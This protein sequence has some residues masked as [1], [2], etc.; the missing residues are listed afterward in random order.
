M[1]GFNIYF[2]N[3][4]TGH[5]ALIAAAIV[6]VYFFVYKQYKNRSRLLIFTRI[7][8]F[9]VLILMIL[10]P[11]ISWQSRQTLKSE[12]LFFIDNSLSF[13]KQENYDRELIH[14]NIK[15]LNQKL[16]DKGLKPTYFSFA[17]EL[18]PIPNL[19][20]LDNKGQNTNLANIL[21]YLQSQKNR[22][23]RGALIVS[24]GVAT[25][26]QVPTSFDNY[27]TGPVFTSGLGDTAAQRDAS[28]LDVEMPGTA[29]VDDTVNISA[30]INPASRSSQIQVSLKVDGETIQTKQIKGTSSYQRTTLDFQYVP[31]KPGSQ[32]IE[33]VIEDDQDKNLFN[34]Q[35]QRNMKITL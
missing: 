16:Q 33:M 29:Q 6:L 17:E 13:A 28:L 4:E 9:I 3:F 21:T 11:V 22:N 26:G 27:G 7:A 8:I 12:F 30:E 32:N 23:I 20:E 25:Q 15:N 10:K 2:E 14:N 35:L 31:E 24:D 5:L 1:S 34:N 19:D 18:K